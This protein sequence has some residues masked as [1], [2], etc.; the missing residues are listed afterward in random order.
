MFSRSANLQDHFTSAGAIVRCEAPVKQLSLQWRHNERDGVS[1]H[2]PHDCLHNRLFS[3]RSKKTSRSNV[4][5]VKR[6]MSPFDDVI[7]YEKHNAS[8][9]SSRNVNPAATKQNAT[10]MCAYFL[11][12]NCI[13]VLLDLAADSAYLWRMPY[14]KTVA[15][16][17]CPMQC[18]SSTIAAKMQNMSLTV[19]WIEFD[20]FSKVCLTANIHEY[21]I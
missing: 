16:G 2:Q 15:A 9:K 6:K 8:D 1:N 4:T 20:T 17:Y 11:A 13:T 10:Q 12:Y 5:V 3:R 7:M 18:S 14:F 21:C 19:Q